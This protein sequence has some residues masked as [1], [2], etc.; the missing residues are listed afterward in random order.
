MFTE[1]DAESWFALI[2]EHKMM[3]LLRLMRIEE[4]KLRCVE[5]MSMLQ[6]K[7]SILLRGH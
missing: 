3:Q 7:G 5:H 4:C 6:R 1:D 2:L